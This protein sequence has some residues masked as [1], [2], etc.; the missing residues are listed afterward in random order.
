MGGWAQEKA[1]KGNAKIQEEKAD[2][3]EE[4]AQ[5]RMVTKTIQ[6]LKSKESEVKSSGAHDEKSKRID[7]AVQT[8]ELKAETEYRAEEQRIYAQKNKLAEERA[9]Q[10]QLQARVQGKQVRLD[11]ERSQS[12][13]REAA[14]KVKRAAERAQ[15]GELV[16]ERRHSE[17]LQEQQQAKKEGARKLDRASSAEAQ[18]DRR[19]ADMR[20]EAKDEEK[21]G[22]WQQQS[23][24]KE[25]FKNKLKTNRWKVR[26]ASTNRHCRSCVGKI[27]FS[28]RRTKS[29]LKSST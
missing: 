15:K 20:L 7:E 27:L 8:K 19:A 14:M 2:L 3:A 13:Q 11:E 1:Q 5:G 21:F 24:S 29:S 28:S 6:K 9:R 22:K 23:E 12:S 4:K 10:K 16:R 25:Q 17:Q 26:R 18:Y